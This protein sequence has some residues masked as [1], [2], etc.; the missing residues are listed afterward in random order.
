MQGEIKT[1]SI[2]PEVRVHIGKNVELSVSNITNSN[3]TTSETGEA[4]PWYMKDGE[5]WPQ[6]CPLSPDTGEREAS[7]FPEEAPGDRMISQLMY[8]PPVGTIPEDQDS[9]DVPLKKILFWTGAS[10]WGVKPG[11]G[12]FL[13]VF[14]GR[15][16]KHRE[17]RE[18]FNSHLSGEVS[19]LY[20]CYQ[21]QAEGFW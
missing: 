20:L 7:L 2:E 3:S 5:V 4:R 10:G 21:H 1:L 18:L 6:H 15:N 12:V 17:D 16:T 9:P 14:C 8:L 11:R 13:K 19:S